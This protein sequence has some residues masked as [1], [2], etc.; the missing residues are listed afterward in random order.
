[1]TR[2][3]PFINEKKMHNGRGAEFKHE[4]KYQPKV[5]VGSPHIRNKMGTKINIERGN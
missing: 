4:M 2:Y 5:T 1:M 3:A